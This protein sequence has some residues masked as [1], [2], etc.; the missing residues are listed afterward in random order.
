MESVRSYRQKKGEIMKSTDISKATS[1]V[2]TIL[3]KERMVFRIDEY[4]KPNQV[5]WLIHDD[6]S[7]ML[8]E[9]LTAEIMQLV[10]TRLNEQKQE[11]IEQLEG[12]GVDYVDETA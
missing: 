5:W 11:Y 2:N 8:D 3:E 10:K 9:E 4:Y 7:V 12:I 1:I 6:N